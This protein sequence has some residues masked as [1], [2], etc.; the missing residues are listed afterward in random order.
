ML[1]EATRINGLELENRFVRSA[2][3]EGMAFEN[4]APTP[5]LID[6]MTA[7]AAGR[8]G[9]I[10]S[11]HAYI[12]R[13][14]QASPLQTGIYHD[15]LIPPLRAMTE[16]VHARRGRI[17]VQLA[18]AGRF[19]NQQMTGQPPLALSLKDPSQSQKFQEATE[20]DLKQL[21]ADFAAAARRAKAA[22]FDG[23]QLH[24]AHGYLLSQ[25][26]SPA[27][28]QRKDNYGGRLENRVRLL[29]ETV[30]VVR[31]EV[32]RNFPLLVKLNSA[33]FVENGLVLE[34]SLQVGRWLQTAG[35]DVIEVSG[36]TIASGEMSPV[37]KGINTEE[38]EAY[39][40]QATKRF[41]EALQIP[42]I[43]VGGIRSLA[44]AEELL[45]EEVA[46]YFSLARP[47]IREPNL[48]QR[49][50]EGDRRKARCLSDNLCHDAARAGEGLYCVIERRKE[51]Q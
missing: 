47:L 22:G 31:E 19:A 20:E 1:F 10:I 9:L 41:K 3:W 5:A 6:L 42:I 18:H 43:L 15:D 40:R 2:T 50:A 45:E 25:S 13:Q 28:N 11:S 8:V 29:L 24:A 34:E 35:V 26:L 48:I 7:L 37:R 46:D 30:S 49:W 16:A 32:G 12:T 27:F 14:G 44:V 33:D 4:G 39:F 51:R 17:V 21:S 23:V 36:G 38:K